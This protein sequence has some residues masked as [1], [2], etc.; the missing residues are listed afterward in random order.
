MLF[1]LEKSHLAGTEILADLCFSGDGWVLD[2]IK[3]PNVLFLGMRSQYLE[4]LKTSPL[5]KTFKRQSCKKPGLLDVYCQCC[6][7]GFQSEEMCFKADARVKTNKLKSYRLS[8][9]IK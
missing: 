9:L 3:R 4:P 2:V 1:V 7:A 5:M 8:S 6:E